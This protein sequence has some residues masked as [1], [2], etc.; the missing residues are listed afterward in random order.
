MFCCL[1]PISHMENPS[2]RTHFQRPLRAFKK[3]QDI[4]CMCFLLTLFPILILSHRLMIA[5]YLSR[6][7]VLHLLPTIC[8]LPVSHLVY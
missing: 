6:Y 7:L 8:F 1:E 3:E 5:F 4:K 2:V